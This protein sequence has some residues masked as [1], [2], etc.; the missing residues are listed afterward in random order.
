MRKETQTLIF[1]AAANLFAERGYDGVTVDEIAAKAGVSK[2]SIF[3]N[4]GSKEGM[5]ESLLRE[6]VTTLGE[7]TRQ[8]AANLTGE[9]ALRALTQTL[10]EHIRD[11]PTIAKVIATEMFHLGRDWR[12]VMSPV[13]SESLAVFEGVISDATGNPNCQ[14][15]AMSTFGA[16]LLAGLEWVVFEPDKSL[17]EVHEG[18]WSTIRAVLQP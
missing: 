2:G 13:R 4:F 6:G 9:E 17:A 18:V 14:I 15:Q 7:H 3:Y 1:H 16:T 5:Y 12:E 11:Y 10:L 8:A